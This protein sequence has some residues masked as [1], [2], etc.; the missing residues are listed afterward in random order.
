MQADQP[1]DVSKRNF[2]GC[3][4]DQPCGLSTEPN[5]QEVQENSDFDFEFTYKFVHPGQMPQ[6][7]ATARFILAIDRK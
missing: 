4:D 3:S 5:Y 1:I 7:T 6:V 2:Q